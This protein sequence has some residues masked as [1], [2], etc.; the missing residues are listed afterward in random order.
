V[1]ERMALALEPAQQPRDAG[2]V[3]V[4]SRASGAMLGMT[5]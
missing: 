2:D 1:R 3:V 5:T 4:G